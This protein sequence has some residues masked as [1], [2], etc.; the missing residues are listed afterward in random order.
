LHTPCHTADSICYYAEDRTTDSRAVFTGDTLF[1]AGCGRFFE[2]TAEE[3]HRALNTTLAALPDDTKVYP[4]HEYTKSNIK[5]VQSVLDTPPVQKMVSF[6]ESEKETAGKF[7]LGNEKEY[8]VF[9][10]VDDPKIQQTVGETEPV[11]VMAK[12]RDMKNSFK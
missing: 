9:M 7:T 11:K 3:M 12:L 5:F 1:I 8:N 10:M 2:G 6:C 4:G